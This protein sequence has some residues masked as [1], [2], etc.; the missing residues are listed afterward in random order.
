MLHELGEVAI[1]GQFWRWLL[2]CLGERSYWA[3]QPS[4]A[5]L[6][7]DKGTFCD[8]YALIA[9]ISGPVPR[10]FMTRVRL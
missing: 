10:I 7:Q 5:A 3:L 6:R 1:L 9:A 4:W 2:F 8:G